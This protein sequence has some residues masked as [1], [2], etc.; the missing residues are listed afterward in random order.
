MSQTGYTPILIY[1]SST[2]GNTPAA[3]NLTNSTL[4][5]ELAINIT[6]GKLFY[7][8]NA[9]AVQVIGWKVVPATAGGTGQTSYAVG[10]ILY[11]SSTTALSKLADVATGN[12]L[13][14]GGVNTAPSWGKIG[15]TTH[16]SGTLPIANGGTNQTA[17]TSPSSSIA[18]LV[19]FDGTS[20]QN[21]TTTSHVG[22]NATTNTFY[23]NNVN[24]S[25]TV[26]LASALP[27]AQGGTGLTSWT[28]G[29]LLYASGTTTLTNGSALTFSG[30]NLSIGATLPTWY[31]NSVVTQIGTGGV[32]EARDNYA[33]AMAIAANAYIDASGNDVYLTTNYATRFEQS[34]GVMRWKV[35]AS[36]TAGTNI[37]FTTAMQ[38]H[39]SGGV[40][41]GNT[42]DPGAKALSVS[43]TMFLNTNSTGLQ[44]ARS[45]SF[46]TTG[47]CTQYVSHSTSDGNG[48]SYAEY[49]YNGTKIG[50]ITQV[51][52][53][54]VA[55]N[56]TSDSRL[57][58][59]F[60]VVNETD[61]IENTIIHDV[62]Y[63][64]DD[65][66][67]HMLSVMAQE[68]II[69]N[70]IAV[71]KGSDEIDENGNLKKP[72]QVDY[73]KYIPAL[74]VEVKSLRKRVAQLEAKG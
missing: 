68:A 53:T 63:I 30:K 72:W 42:T 18:G 69:V 74:I 50:S 19:W 10:D 39:N 31:S 47:G 5:S 48:D 25:G 61:I 7:K 67:T 14:S 4:G 36:G 62:T 38:L 20:F 12:A 26:T 35:A 8:D 45:M 40:S 23:A 73:S 28:S 13:I 58:N 52:T 1:S 71:S 22:Y 64:T 32:I 51:L 2:G 21:D 6:D 65:T 24:F 16:V 66:Q 3:G 55:F 70:P 9:N 27:V 17:F 34:A 11:A 33:P 56:T 46:L 41:I 49:G 29:G 60:G 15:L 59:D 57:K 44:T 54:G 43:G 37:S